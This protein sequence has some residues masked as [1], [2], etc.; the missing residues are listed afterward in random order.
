MNGYPRR[1][2]GGRTPFMLLQEYFPTFP[3]ILSFFDPV[4]KEVC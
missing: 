4:P 3:K 1:I 2:L